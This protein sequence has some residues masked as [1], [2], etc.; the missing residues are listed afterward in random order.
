MLIHWDVC[1][2]AGGAPPQDYLGRERLRFTR[3]GC[4]VGES[5]SKTHK[6]GAVSNGVKRNTSLVNCCPAATRIPVFLP[7]A[8]TAR[9]CFQMTLLSRSAI[10]SPAF[11][12]NGDYNATQ[13]DERDAH[14]CSVVGVH[15]ASSVWRESSRFSESQLSPSLFLFWVCA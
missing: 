7:I 15:F 9:D 6:Y 4:Y 8:L 10:T 1:V 5:F 12:V 14:I 13:V 11:A 3:G 2:W